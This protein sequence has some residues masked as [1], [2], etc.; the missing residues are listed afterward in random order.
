[1]AS[2]TSL[3][4]TAPSPQPPPSVMRISRRQAE[5]QLARAEEEERKRREE[6]QLATAA[7]SSRS[8]SRTSRKA[9]PAAAEKK[10]QPPRASKSSRFRGV[11]WHRGNRN[12]NCQIQ[13]NGKRESIGSFD[14]EVEA[15]RAYDTFAATRGFPPRNFPDVEVNAAPAR[16][17]AVKR[18]V[19]APQKSSQYRGV[20]RDPRWNKWQARIRVGGKTKHIGSYTEEVDAARAYDEFVISNKLNKPL[21]FATAGHVVHNAFSSKYAGVSWVKSG[22][23]KKWYV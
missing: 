21:N 15:A 11:S 1:M 13:V 9:A 14:D 18:G 20:R 12:W 19:S 4:H 6:Q 5:K 8:S 2:T 10:P 3:T 23:G 7:S 17:A 22:R 16:K